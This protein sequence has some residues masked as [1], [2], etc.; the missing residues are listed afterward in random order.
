MTAPGTGGQG[1][2]HQPG[3]PGYPGGPPPLGDPNPQPAAE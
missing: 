2:P 1:Q 3:P